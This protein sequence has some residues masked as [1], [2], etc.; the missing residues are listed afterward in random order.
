MIKY[1]KS[2]NNNKV[3]ASPYTPSKS[4]SRYNDFYAEKKKRQQMV[5]HQLKRKNTDKYLPPHLRPPSAQDNY[6]DNEIINPGPTIKPYSIALK[7]PN[8]IYDQHEQQKKV[9]IHKQNNTKPNGTT[10]QDIQALALQ[11]ANHLQTSSEKELALKRI[12]GAAATSNPLILHAPGTLPIYQTDGF[13][14]EQR[15]QCMVITGGAVVSLMVTFVA[16]L[17]LMGYSG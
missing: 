13:S 17:A 3:I 7:S 6:N 2:N 14:F 11:Q 9:I 10:Y 15:T 5:K 12:V 16:I 4:Q 8:A 1:L